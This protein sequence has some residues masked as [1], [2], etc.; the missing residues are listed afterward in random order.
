MR[1]RVIHGPA[2]EDFLRPLERF[3]PERNRLALRGVD[4][5]LRGIGWLSGRGTGCLRVPLGS[6]AIAR[7][8]NAGQ[9]GLAVAAARCGLHFRVLSGKDPSA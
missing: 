3:G 6:T 1:R 9:V 4:G 7:L 8:V 2:I 5:R